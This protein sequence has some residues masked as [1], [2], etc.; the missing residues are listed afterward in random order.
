[1]KEADRKSAWILEVQE[2][3]ANKV[4]I[5]DTKY[6]VVRIVGWQSIYVICACVHVHSSLDHV[7][8]VIKEN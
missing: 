6:H 2:A 5:R 3:H 1:M 7:Y 8:A 4:V